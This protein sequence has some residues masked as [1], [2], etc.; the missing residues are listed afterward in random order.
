MRMFTSPTIIFKDFLLRVGNLFFLNSTYRAKFYAYVLKN[1]TTEGA[2]IRKNVTI[3]GNGTLYIGQGTLI[4]EECFLDCSGEIYIE[5]DIAIGMRTTIL[6]STHSIG[7]IKRCGI[8]KRK[9]TIIRK[10]TWI[11]S[12]VIIYPGV[13][14]GEGCVISAGEVVNDDIGDN[15]ILK[16]KVLKKL[17]YK[18]K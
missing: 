10:N 6:T 13:E 18:V 17:I 3:Y 7:E 16:N 11:G 2:M 15:M 4:N 9:R 1:I 5:E 14:I 12:N 8:A